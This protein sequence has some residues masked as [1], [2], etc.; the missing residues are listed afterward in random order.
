MAE[1]VSSPPSDLHLIMVQ[2][3]PFTSM[4]LRAVQMYYAVPGQPLDPHGLDLMKA[5]GGVA[6]ALA[7]IATCIQ[8]ADERG[9][10]HVQPIMTHCVAQLGHIVSSPDPARTGAMLVASGLTHDGRVFETPARGAPA[11][12]S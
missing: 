3:S 2:A 4:L 11:E 12:P 10:R 5:F 7:E 8:K 9:F 1:P 6:G